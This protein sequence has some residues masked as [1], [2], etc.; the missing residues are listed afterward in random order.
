M[1]PLL[2]EDEGS[3]RRSATATVDER[4][5]G[6]GLKALKDKDTPAIKRL[7]H[8]L[9]VTQVSELPVPLPVFSS[10]DLPPAGGLCAPNRGD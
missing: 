5:I 10:Y 3:G 8:M 9:A 1:L 7:F 6:A 4:V 2:R